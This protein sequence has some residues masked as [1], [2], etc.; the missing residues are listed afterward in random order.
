MSSKVE[1]KLAA[2]MFTD[3]AGY[4]ALSAKDSLKASELLKTQRDI[5]K[6]IVDKYAGSWMKEI[7]DGLLLTFDSVTSAVEC[8]IEIQKT[9]QGME[10]LDL[11]IGLHEGEVIK[12]NDDVIGDDVNVA[13]RIEPF[14]AIGGIAIS[15]K[16]QQAISS[17]KEFETKY[18]GKPQL[19]GVSQKI[20]VYCITSHELPETNISKVSAKLE[21]ESSF[22][23]F[24]VTGGILTVIGVTFWIAVGVFDFSFGSKREVPSVGIL[25]MENLGDKSEEFWSSSMTAD[26]IT[27]VADAGL[28]RVSPL[29]DIL[30]I[31]EELNTIDKAK[32]LNVKYIFTHN[33]HKQENSFDLWYQLINV[34]DGK[35]L[36]SK[37]INN[38]LDSTNHIVGKLA[39]EILI[40]LNV[41]TQQNI[42]KISTN[43][44]VAYEYYLRGKYKWNKRNSLEDIETARGLLERAL[45]LDEN[46]FDALSELGFT[47]LDTHDYETS[48]QYF[49][50]HL[51]LAQKN[52]DDE[53]SASY[54]AI[55]LNY[56]YREDSDK[57]LSY[58][59]KALEIEKKIGNKK[60]I[61]SATLN[62]AAEYYEKEDIE[63]AI[64]T[65]K[66][67]LSLFRELEDKSS[68]SMCLN[69]L[70]AF[71]EEIEEYDIALDY[72]FQTL[73]IS[74]ELNEEVPLAYTYKT[75]GSIYYK[76]RNIEKA[77]ENYFKAID[78][79]KKIEYKKGEAASLVSIADVYGASLEYEKSIDYYK[80]ALKINRAIDNKHQ[81]AYSLNR[82]GVLY[83]LIG[84]FD[85]ALEHYMEAYE[86]VSKLNIESVMNTMI[87]NIGII[88]FQKE[89]F[90]TALE[91]FEK[92]TKDE[93]KYRGPSTYA[94]ALSHLNL[95][96]KKLGMK[97]S[98]DELFA[99][100]EEENKEEYTYEVNYRIYELIND[101]TFLELSYSL[102]YEK[103]NIAKEKIKNLH[104]DTI[105]KWL[106]MPTP[107][108][109]IE[110]Y[111]RVFK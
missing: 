97:F 11:R 30:S 4:T 61:A 68:I 46:S 20:E 60:G 64:V 26:L 109:I 14:S 51:E 28:I 70:S 32:E 31:N 23:I 5:L 91:Y 95:T 3:I 45:D 37:K 107:K 78:F 1:R 105:E 2:I 98:N 24:T 90:T 75:I 35:T 25:M 108:A 27:R 53:L 43:N 92:Y 22:N 15:H 82:M 41:S 10:D 36:F 38:S 48:M 77:F 13:S 63:K 42:K 73:T 8:A 33:F 102:L 86:I 58:Y 19:K 111:N 50:K 72:A 93:R 74:K 44:P 39:D 12:Q 80:Q 87:L 71:H 85:N 81:I 104:P 96:Y 7:G 101:K 94:F 62:I 59:N 47:Y 66:K 17:N 83:R 106:E 21:K 55:A 29:N 88:Y 69:N 9:T 99:L 65:T 110:E 6:P 103:L 54:N 40:S 84:E 52:D 16:I 79:F 49:Q 100:L 57:A 89:D 18:I 56:S 34:V 67:S 76:M